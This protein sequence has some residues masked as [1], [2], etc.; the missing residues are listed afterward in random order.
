MRT[1]ITFG[2]FLNVAIIAAKQ[3]ADQKEPIS[4]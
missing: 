3:G 2:V 1:T 4:H